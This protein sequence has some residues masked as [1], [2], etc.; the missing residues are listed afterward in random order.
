MPQCRKY[1][2]SSKYAAFKILIISQEVLQNAAVSSLKVLIM[3]QNGFMC[4]CVCARSI[5]S[6][7]WSKNKTK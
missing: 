6:I 7:T 5:I 1:S 4:V 3:Q 2:I